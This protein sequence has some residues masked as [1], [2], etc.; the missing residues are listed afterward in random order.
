MIKKHKKVVKVRRVTSLQDLNPGVYIPQVIKKQ[1]KKSP[2]Y[3]QDQYAQDATFIDVEDQIRDSFFQYDKQQQKLQKISDQQFAKQ[4]IQ[5]RGW[6]NGVQGYIDIPTRNPV[7]KK[8][9]KSQV[10]QNHE[11]PKSQKQSIAKSDDIKFKDF[12]VNNGKKTISDIVNT[13]RQNKNKI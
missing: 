5:K 2:I 8:Q 6:Q 1:D 4:H 12:V 3:H 10:I 11:M 13:P 9:L 7:Q